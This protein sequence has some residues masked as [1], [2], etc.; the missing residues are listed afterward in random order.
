MIKAVIFDLDGT[1]LNRDESLKRFIDKQYERFHEYLHHIP[2]ENYTQRFI[3]LDHR[4]YV[5]KEEVYKDLLKEFDITGLTW[6]E[7]LQDYL[8]YFSQH[9][10]PFPNLIQMLE[11]LRQDKFLIGIITNGRGQFQMDSIN[12]LAIKEYIDT[13][14]ISEWEGIKKPEPVIFRR[15]LQRLA[16]SSNEAVFIGDH[17]EKDVKAAQNVG[18]KAVWKRDPQWQHGS[19][20]LVIDD[21]WELPLLIQQLDTISGKLK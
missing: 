4:G 8:T 3:E 16:V 7:C 17:P 5:G 11:K 20:E 13:I 1:L 9:C 6:E 15:A 19:T 18:M 14:L 12:A 10:V 2:K 21:L